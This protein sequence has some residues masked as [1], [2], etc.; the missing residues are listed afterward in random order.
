MKETK[1]DLHRNSAW[2]DLKTEKVRDT[3]WKNDPKPYLGY[4]APGKISSAESHLLYKIPQWLGSGNYADVGVYKGKSTAILG[5]GL[6]TAGYSGEVYSVD[7]FGTEPEGTEKFSDPTIPDLL[8]K[9]FEEQNLSP[10]LSIMKG[11]SSLSGHKLQV[12]KTMLQFVFLDAD[13]SYEGTKRDFD[14]WSRMI[15]KGGMIAFHDC[16]FYGVNQTIKEMNQKY[17]KFVRQVFS[18]KLFRK[19]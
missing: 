8:T 7:F 1:S 19:V 4:P 10:R 6:T 2:L 16:D 11:D 14:I 18:I 9:Y 3:E 5:H 17:W 15:I 13:H 12:L